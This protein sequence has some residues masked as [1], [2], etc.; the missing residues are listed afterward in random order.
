[1]MADMG[2]EQDVFSRQ[3]DDLQ[4]RVIENAI[5][6]PPPEPGVRTA[7]CGIVEQTPDGPSVVDSARLFRFGEAHLN[8]P[9]VQTRPRRTI[10]RAVFGG[11]LFRHYGH[12]LLEGMARTW[13]TSPNRDL[14][15]LYISI[16]T[17][18]IKS[19][20]RDAFD[21]VGL[22]GR[23]EVVSR[24]GGAV[25]VK[26]LIVPDPGMEIGSWI[27]P[28]HVETMGV[29]PARPVPGRRLW[30]SRSGIEHG[31]LPNEIDVEQRL[32]AQGWEIVR[33][34]TLPLRSQVELLASASHIAGVE[35]SAIHTL[36]FV[37]GYQGTVDI[38][39][40]MRRKNFGIIG[41]ALGLDQV[42][43]KPPIG[44]KEKRRRSATQMD[45]EWRDVDPDALV[46]ALNRSI[47]RRS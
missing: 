7:R 38:V 31:G 46:A 27:H 9:D 36:M 29:V 15:R 44:E 17:K 28:T 11:Y 47:T 4:I 45:A 14:P 3:P 37:R 26:E 5:I 30:L 19:Y 1:M 13:W 16:S 22:G 25:L 24:D 39:P 18:E 42:F 10:D 23:H 2:G 41:D 33:P 34:E 12:F 20:M 21:I 43:L 32:S 35:G 40:R 8:P 6:V